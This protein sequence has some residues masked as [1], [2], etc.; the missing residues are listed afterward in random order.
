MF[1]RL[2]VLFFS[3]F[4]AVS[5]ALGAPRLSPEESAFFSH[6]S[7]TKEFEQARKERLSSIERF[8]NDPNIE[9]RMSEQEAYEFF[10]AETSFI[11]G[12]L[13]FA[14]NEAPR[15]FARRERAAGLSA[16]LLVVERYYLALRSPRATVTAEELVGPTARTSLKA[17]LEG[18]PGEKANRDSVFGILDRAE[19][20]FRAIAMHS[21]STDKDIL[22]HN[23]LAKIL[24]AR[25]EPSV[26]G[27][28]LTAYQRFVG[29]EAELQKIA[30]LRE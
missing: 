6:L 9:I 1:R 18:F 3:V 7:E 11:G 8:Q 14:R 17:I 2:P 5:S 10:K 12:L 27:N 25:A 20:L 23:D 21:T 29:A 4:L 26:R 13:L 16:A 15:L 24:L 22:R 30:K 19:A 28:V